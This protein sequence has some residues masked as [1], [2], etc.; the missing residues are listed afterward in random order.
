MLASQLALRKSFSELGF[1]IASL[2]L[3]YLLSEFWPGLAIVVAAAFCVGAMY[4]A[5]IDK[6]AE[7]KIRSELRS[8]RERLSSR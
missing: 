6:R 2:F 1:L 7:A 8:D 4:S 5:H 3:A